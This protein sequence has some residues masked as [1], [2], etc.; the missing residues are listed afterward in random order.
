MLLSKLCPVTATSP[1]LPSISFLQFGDTSWFS[2]TV[3]KAHRAG[4]TTETTHLVPVVQSF[5]FTEHFFS[6]FLSFSLFDFS[7]LKLQTFNGFP[8]HFQFSL[9]LD[10]LFLDFLLLPVPFHL[11]I[12]HSTFLVCPLLIQK[13][14]HDKAVAILYF[15]C[16]LFLLYR[17][18]VRL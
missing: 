7:Y 15:P 10:F 12:I 13:D 18:H 11:L 2:L 17:K 8:Y 4:C 9:L 5:T 6:L 3:Q 16:L 1:Y 14:C